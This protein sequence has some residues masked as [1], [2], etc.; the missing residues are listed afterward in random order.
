MSNAGG[1][2][3][4]TFNGAIYNHLELRRDLEPKYRFA[5]NSDTE[6]LIHGYEEYGED[7]W[8]KLQ[9]MFAF[10]LWDKRQERFFLVRD[11]FGIKPLYYALHNDRLIFASQIKGI[12]AAP[13]FDV[14]YDPE[15]I[16]NFF[17]HFF[18]PGP[19][20]GVQHIRL[21]E[22]G[23]YLRFDRQGADVH[24]YYRLHPNP[25]YSLTQD[26]L[27]QQLPMAASE[28]IRK[29]QI[30]DV[31]V[32]V[33][34][35]SG[36]D[37]SILFKEM[38]SAGGPPLNTY[39]LG[40]EDGSSYDESADVGDI[41]KNTN[42]RNHVS[43][44]STNDFEN[45]VRDVVSAC[46]S[47]NANPGLLA[48]YQYMRVAGSHGKVAMVG[49]G[50][51][52][53]FAGYKTYLANQ[54]HRS[55]QLVPRA[56]RTMMLKAT[57]GLPVGYGKYSWDYLLRKFLEGSLH[58]AEKAHYWWRTIFTD[59]EKQRLFTDDFI[60]ALDHDVDSS[61]KYLERFSEVEGSFD[62]RALY[63]DFKLFLG[64]NALVAADHLAMHF[65]L[66]TR[67]PF[68]HQEFVEFAMRI[69]F[70]FKL[71]GRETKHILRQ[72]FA[73]KLPPQ[74]AKRQKQGVV[75]PMGELFRGPLKEYAGD[76]INSDVMSGLP[77]F[78]PGALG[79]VV[80]DHMAGRSD[81]G[82]K[83]WCLIYL[84]EWHRQFGQS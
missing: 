30:S 18:V 61:Y 17:S 44:F 27:M 33:L 79:E 22:G 54:Y 83:I 19:E 25:D 29:S 73:D 21:L 9:G 63:G 38:E 24:Q 14:A 11:H 16:S 34:L 52:E 15:G 71:R 5:S 69:P 65:S 12:L 40:F 43:K 81:N 46:D 13:D 68:L 32:G 2:V 26:D 37:S 41:T 48:I 35:S 31:P 23:Y 78:R 28:A 62:D 3:W 51:D 1:S 42:S 55:I 53:L 36:I 50:P 10:A 75:A 59:A 74:T 8:P 66:E 45:Q 67:P 4:V 77:F 64:D 56:V 39:T 76:T 58:G 84:A 70:H 7:L 20:T 82:F 57:R 72:A 49:S 47:F 60:A 80:D 6:V